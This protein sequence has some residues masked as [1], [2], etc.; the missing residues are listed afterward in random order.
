VT[1]TPATSALTALGVPFVEHQYAHDAANT[2]FGLEAASVLGLEPDRVF[3]TLLAEVT[4]A[5]P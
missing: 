4:A 2:S 5:S 3:K 1:A